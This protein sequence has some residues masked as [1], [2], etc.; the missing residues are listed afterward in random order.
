MEFARAL[1]PDDLLFLCNDITNPEV[2]DH[3]LRDLEAGRVKTVLAEAD[4]ELLG[5]GSLWLEETF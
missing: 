1:P 4:G 5:Y 3:W 2:V